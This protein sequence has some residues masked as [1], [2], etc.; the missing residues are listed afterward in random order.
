MN[1]FKKRKIIYREDGSPYLIRWNIFECKYFSLKL[2]KILLSDYDCPH[3][4]PWTF[5]S[6]IFAGGYVEYREVNG[7][8]ISE[9]KHPLDILYRSAE[10]KHRLELHQPAWTLVLTLKK[11]RQWGFWT[12]E[13]W[14]P[15]FKYNST[16]SCE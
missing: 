3:D 1:F 9:I 11:R 12:K 8:W 14:L 7:K 4:H 16:N 2:H 13:G 5:I 15:W 6:L 10:T